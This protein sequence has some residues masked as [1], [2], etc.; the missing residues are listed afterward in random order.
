MWH[1]ALTR[2]KIMLAKKSICFT[3]LPLLLTPVLPTVANAA[4]PTVMVV[5]DSISA[6]WFR[7]SYRHALYREFQNAGCS[8]DMVG[9]QTLTSYSYKRPGSQP[10]IDY[11]SLDQ[12]EPDYGSGE[13]WSVSNPEDDTDHQAFGGIRADQ[14]VSGVEATASGGARVEPIQVYVNNHQ[15]DYMLVHLGTNDLGQEMDKES[16]DQSSFVTKTTNDLKNLVNRSREARADV[17]ILIGDFI[18]RAGEGAAKRDLERQFSEAFTESIRNELNGYRGITTVV[19]VASGF[20]PSEMT[21]DG[22]HPNFR[23]ERHLANAFMQALRDMGVCENVGGNDEL[24]K[25][26]LRNGEWSL[27]T[28]PADPG[29]SG[30]VENLLADDMGNLPYGQNG[31]WVVYAYNAQGRT[32]Q[33][34]GLGDRLRANVGYWI[35]QL[36]GG[37]VELDLPSNLSPAATGSP[38]GCPSGQVCTTSPLVSN[39]SGSQ[40]NLVGFSALN[41]LRFGETRF[42]TTSGA[43]TSG[44]SPDEANTQGIAKNVAYRYRNP[45]N[46]GNPY[47]EMLSTDTFKAWEGVWVKVYSSADSPT[48]VLP[49]RD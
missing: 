38:A 40:W 42:H 27:I 8:V 44:C 49:V 39:A 11:P 34:L 26:T 48:W 43:C 21:Y 1:K 45:N 9:D 33:E 25:H 47:V 35:V 29:A 19:D 12:F 41:N 5:G 10:G 46:A 37:T 18:R 6:G 20:N 24:P 17:K 16:P 31:S 7:P 4:D 14:T 23:G 13:H 22:V 2:K 15:P 30:T 28:I 32:Y 36:S 3:A